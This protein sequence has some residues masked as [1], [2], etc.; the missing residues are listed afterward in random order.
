MKELISKIPEPLKEAIKEFVRVILLAI[1]PVI[2]A[3][4]ESGE[5]DPKVLV[6]VGLLAF[7]RFVDKYLHLNAPEGTAGGLTRF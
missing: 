7:L 2:I 3:S 5:L 6:T 4:V 1:L